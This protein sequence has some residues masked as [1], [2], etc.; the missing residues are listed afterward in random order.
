MNDEK[1]IELVRQYSV[2]YNLA[3]PKYMDPKYKMTVWDEIGKHL[4]T[5]C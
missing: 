1:L 5:T 3:D 2:L 4:N